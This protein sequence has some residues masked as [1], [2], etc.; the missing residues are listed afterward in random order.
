[1]PCYPH[2]GG[3]W[4]L[5]TLPRTTHPYEVTYTAPYAAT[6]LQ[7]T[8]LDPPPGPSGGLCCSA[9]KWAL[10]S[11]INCPSKFRPPALRATSYSLGSSLFYIKKI[12]IMITIEYFRL[13]TPNLDL[14][15]SCRARLSKFPTSSYLPIP[16]CRGVNSTRWQGCGRV[17][18]LVRGRVRA[19]CTCRVRPI[20]TNCA[21]TLT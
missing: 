17:R 12:G 18:G 13:R 8:E 1:M 4:T 11:S 16:P 6:P 10:N 2:A 9:I 14:E 20:C 21:S 3:V 7:P 15:V 19:E 5:R